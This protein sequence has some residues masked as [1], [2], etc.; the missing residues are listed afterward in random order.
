MFELITR[1]I[2]IVVPP[3]REAIVLHGARNTQ[4]F[5]EEHPEPLAL[6]NKWECVKCFPLTTLEETVAASKKFQ[7]GESE[8]FVVRDASFRYLFLSSLALFSFLLFLFSLSSFL[9]SLSSFLCHLLSFFLFVTFPSSR[10][11]KIKSPL[12]VA[13]AHL[14]MADKRNT[15]KRQMLKVSPRREEKRRGRRKEEEVR[16]KAEVQLTTNNSSLLQIIRE[17]EGEEF[18]AYFPQWGPLF[19]A[20]KNSYEEFCNRLLHRSAQYYHNMNRSDI[21]RIARMD[22]ALMTLAPEFFAQWIATDRNIRSKKKRTGTEEREQCT[23][24]VVAEGEA[25]VGV[26]DEEA[27]ELERRQT[28]KQFLLRMDL[29][30]LEECMMS[31]YS[32]ASNRFAYSLII[33]KGKKKERGVEVE[34]NGEV[35]SNAKG[36]QQETGET[37]RRKGRGGKENKGVVLD[38]WPEEEDRK[39]RKQSKKKGKKGGSSNEEA[40]WEVVSTRKGRKTNRRK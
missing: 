12:Y 8:G 21:P 40:V 26:E 2:P 20:V 37:D 7:P 9:F 1:Y 39:G 28:L 5:Q 6:K 10:R 18:L 36:T 22:K 24:E 30:L 31:S 38:S 14:S 32:E 11:V 16:G 35:T 13:L 19:S 4:T 17:N 34:G 27:Y 33:G 23:E 29:A 3:L 25:E 15:N